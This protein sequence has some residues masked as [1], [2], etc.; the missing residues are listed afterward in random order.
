MEVWKIALFVR[1]CCDAFL[2]FRR[3]AVPSETMVKAIV[4]PGS[5]LVI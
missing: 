5:N 3:F 2:C 4:F 1:R